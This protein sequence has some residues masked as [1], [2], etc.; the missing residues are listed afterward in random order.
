MAYSLL[1]EHK[2]KQKETKEV[3]RLSQN[4]LKLIKQIYETYPEYIVA[5]KFLNSLLKGLVQY[6]QSQDMNDQ[7]LT[8]CNEGL[9]MFEK[10][11]R[12]KNYFYIMEGLGILNLEK[13]LILKQMNN[14]KDQVREA[15]DNSIFY[16]EQASFLIE[17]LFTVRHSYFYASK[18]ECYLE[19]GKLWLEEGKLKKAQVDFSKALANFE[20][21]LEIN[22][23]YSKESAKMRDELLDILKNNNLKLEEEATSKVAN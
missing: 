1:Q 18:G 12:N 15:F 22:P 10:G 19:R 9:E 4:G 5:G 13:A 23:L 16:Y 11:F 17:D 8:Y 21:S 7:A 2:I 14:E 6:Y 20:R 3:E